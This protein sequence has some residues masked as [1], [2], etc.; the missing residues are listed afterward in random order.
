MAQNVPWGEAEPPYPS[1]QEEHDFETAL[2]N[3]K[4]AIEYLWEQI[5]EYLRIGQDDVLEVDGVDPD[6]VSD[7]EWNPESG[8][9]Y[10]DEPEA[11]FILKN[12]EVWTMKDGDEIP[13]RE[14][15]TV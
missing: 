12:G 6:E 3:R 13:K 14:V 9:Y 4:S 7:P 2:N 11:R 8:Y 15:V 5:Q 10:P 1:A